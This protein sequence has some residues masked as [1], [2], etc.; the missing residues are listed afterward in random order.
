[1]QITL[2]II[3]IIIVGVFLFRSLSGEKERIKTLFRIYRAGKIKFPEKSERGLLEMVTEEHIPPGMGIR[4]RNTG[5]T[6][7]Q[8][9]DGVFKSKP[10]DIDELIYHIITLEFPKKYQPYKINFE[11]IRQQNRSGKLSPRDELK[12]TIKNYHKEYLG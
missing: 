9:I 10:L 8:Y 6:G 3:G 4:L 2:I 5:V 11:E 12:L 1:M 7:K